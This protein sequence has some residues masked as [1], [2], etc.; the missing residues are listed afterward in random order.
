MKSLNAKT[1]LLPFLAFFCLF[2]CKKNL[3]NSPSMNADSILIENARVYFQTTTQQS[4]PAA[5]TGNPRLDAAK[6]PYWPS[7]YVVN[8]SKGPTLIIPVFY[9]KD[10]VVS[11]SFNPGQIF[12]LNQLAKLVVYKDS[13]GY[14][15]E[16]ITSF[17]DTAAR[18]INSGTFSGI[19][20]AETWQGQP[21][22][23]YKVSGGQ[24]HII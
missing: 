10:L 7:A 21:V 5:T 11:T 20:F 9:Q 24:V 6:A 14:K 22:N 2:A 19:I 13:S 15:M 12:T 4:A 1:F 23:V 3:S 18:G 17:P 8:L 16:L